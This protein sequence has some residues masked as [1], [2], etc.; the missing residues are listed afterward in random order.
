MTGYVINSTSNHLW[1]EFNSNAS[2]TSQGFRL[3]YTSESLDLSSSLSIF[4]PN[5]TPRSPQEPRGET[6]TFPPVLPHQ[7]PDRF[8]LDHNLPAGSYSV[9]EHRDTERKDQDGLSERRT[10]RDCRLWRENGLNKL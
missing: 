6:A 10:Y 8:S 3:S 1:L 9:S 5:P 7:A 4:G 2:G